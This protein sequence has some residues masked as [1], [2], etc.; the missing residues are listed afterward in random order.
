M[1]VIGDRL[2]RVREARGLSL[3][4]LADRSGVTKAAIWRL[5]Q[6]QNAPRTETLDRLASAL[7][8]ASDYLAGHTSETGDNYALDRL[9]ESERALVLAL[10]EHRPG[11]A[12]KLIGELLQEG[13][14][15]PK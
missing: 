8:V 12:L 7:E 3:Q 5:E 4:E 9:T 14:Q 1:S 2:R 6:G 11:D 10:R 15:S 13:E